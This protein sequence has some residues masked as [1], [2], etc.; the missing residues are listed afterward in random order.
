VD[1]DLV[2]AERALKRLIEVDPSNLRAYGQLALLYQRQDRLPEALVEFER[3]AKQQSRPVAPET[4][5]GMILQV[6]E[7]LNDAES[8]YQRALTVDA[9]VAG[10]AANNLAWIYAETGGSLDAALQLAQTAKLQLPDLP[11]VDH[12]LGWVYF[13]KEMITLAVPRLEESVRKAPANPVYRLHLGLDYAKQGN[14]A[15]ARE[16]LQSALSLDPRFEGAGEAR[17]ALA[18]LDKPAPAPEAGRS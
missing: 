12:T 7:R 16:A 5:L 4:M 1:N 6:T 17:R 18:A 11:E 3:L 10:V 2:A 14:V 15:K 8:H 13:K 9:A